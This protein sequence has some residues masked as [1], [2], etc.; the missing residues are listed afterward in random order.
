VDSHLSPT[1]RSL[2][3]TWVSF[4]T[5]FGTARLITH[6]IR[7]GWLPWGNI[8]T[9]G[10]HLHHYNFA[11]PPSPASAWSRYAATSGPSGIPR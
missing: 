8:S 9:G 6:G 3:V 5:T 7:G 4:G 1:K 10:E 2:V 11:S